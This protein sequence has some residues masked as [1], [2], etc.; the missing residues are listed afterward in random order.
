MYIE[1]L[2]KKEC[3]RNSDEN[4]CLACGLCCD[5][6][7]I[8]FVALEKEEMPKLK[9]LM[10]IEETHGNSFFLQPCSSYCNGCTIY[11]DR[12]TNCDKFNCGLLNSVTQ[13]E[14]TFEDALERI[15]EVKQRKD[16]IL[17]QIALLQIEFKSPS[18]YFQMIELKK[19]L[20]KLQLTS[21]LTLEQEELVSNLFQLDSL[22]I[23]EFDVSLD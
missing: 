5:G 16:I 2:P 3:N 18:F 8:G 1:K 19:V 7:F 4:I 14:I 10:E 23:K 21:L 20:K 6:T 11:K 9:Q 13:K 15:K 22:L 12:P 17:K